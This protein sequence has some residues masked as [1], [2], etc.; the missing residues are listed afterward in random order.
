MARLDDWGRKVND[1]GKSRLEPSVSISASPPA[2]VDGRAARYWGRLQVLAGIVTLAGLLAMPVIALLP[3]R[4][5]RSMLIPVALL[6]ALGP[7][8]C[9][10]MLAFV[11]KAAAIRRESAAGCTTLSGQATHYWQLDPKTGEVLQRPGK[12]KP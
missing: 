6:V 12:R 2:L 9:G 4:S 8:W 3:D 7:G 10:S 5:A 1:E 11:K